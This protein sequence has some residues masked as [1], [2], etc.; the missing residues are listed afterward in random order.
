[1]LKSNKKTTFCDSAII[2]LLVRQLASSKVIFFN[3]SQASQGFFFFIGFKSQTLQDE[4]TAQIY[5]WTAEQ[6]AF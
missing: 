6:G 5:R 3:E 2:K 1:M 4:R